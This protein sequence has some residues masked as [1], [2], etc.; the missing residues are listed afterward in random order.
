[1]S[2]CALLG[3]Y[4]L[5]DN[6]HSL[7]YNVFYGD[8]INTKDTKHP[9]LSKEIVFPPLPVWVTLV[10]LMKVPRKDEETNNSTFYA[11]L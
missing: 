6:H 10:S 9:I 11:G 1:M 3:I 8:T 2:T 5:G 7:L 4:L